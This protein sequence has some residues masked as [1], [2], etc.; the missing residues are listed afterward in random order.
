MDCSLTGCL[1]L[2]CFVYL[3]GMRWDEITIKEKKTS[4]QWINK[5]QQGQGVPEDPAAQLDVQNRVYSAHN[6]GG[7]TLAF[8]TSA[9]GLPVATVENVGWVSKF[10]IHSDGV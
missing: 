3:L 9:K 5:N 10:E 6:S 2:R 4:T 8:R 7:V 1:T